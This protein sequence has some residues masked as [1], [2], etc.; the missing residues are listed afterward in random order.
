MELNK[1]H[2]DL[3]RDIHVIK[4]LLEDDKEFSII[5]L[6]PGKAIGACSH[7]NDEEFFI[8]KGEVLIFVG[9]ERR[10]C[11]EGYHNKFDAGTPHG[12][13][14]EKGAIIIEYGISEQEKLENIKD[15]KM[16]EELNRINEVCL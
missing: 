13:Y 11:S 10:R 16:I 9:D 6:N 4:D 2:S 7:S 12:F 14:S 15:K 1:V 8:L 5:T 3:R